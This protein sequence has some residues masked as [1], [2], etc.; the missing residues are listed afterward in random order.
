MSFDDEKDEL[1]MDDEINELIKIG[2]LY[3]SKNVEYIKN[4]IKD[5]KLNFDSKIQY[6]LLFYFFDNNR[7]YNKSDLS[8]LLMGI[9]VGEVYLM[10]GHTVGFGSVT[11]SQRIIRILEKE[12][13]LRALIMKRWAHQFGFTNSWFYN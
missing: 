2:K 1:I 6:N 12:N 8:Y 4:N 7:G 5:M 9:I 13:P 11:A 10:D 3:S